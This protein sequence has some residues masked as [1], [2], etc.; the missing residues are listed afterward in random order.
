ME[1]IV[2]ARVCCGGVW[3]RVERGQTQPLI[4]G[5]QQV[6]PW[7]TGGLPLCRTTPPPCRSG[8]RTYR[9]S[10]HSLLCHIYAVGCHMP[11]PALLAS[12]ADA[13]ALQASVVPGLCHRASCMPAVCRLALLPNTSVTLGSGRHRN[14]PSPRATA[15]PPEHIILYITANTNFKQRCL[16]LS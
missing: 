7:R 11:H 9:H 14:S 1:G 12:H 13:A 2:E 8:A 5:A 10:F 16:K 6:F 15:A 4:V 3:S